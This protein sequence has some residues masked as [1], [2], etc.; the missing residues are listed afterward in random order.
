MKILALGDLHLGAGADLGAPGERLAEQEQV[1]AWSLQQARERDVDVVLFAGDA[2]Q[3]RKPSVDALLAFERPLVE[4]KNAGGPQVLAIPGNH[5]LSSLDAGCAL[6][7]FHQDGLIRLEREPRVVLVD[8]GALVACLP[9]A[10]TSRLAARLDVAAEDVNSAAAHLL[11]EVARTL[12]EDAG[13]GAKPVILLTHFSI[14]GTS[15]PS[16]LPVDQLREPVLDQDDLLAIGYDAVIAGHIHRAGAFGP[17][18]DR[19]I[20]FGH[21]HQATYGNGLHFYTG[22]PLALNF[23]E[24]SVAHGVWIIDMD[25]APYST[26]LPSPS[27]RFVNL[28]YGIGDHDDLYVDR[29]MSEHDVEGAYVKLR[30]AGT[31]EQM[32]RV[33]VQTYKACLEEDGAHRVFVDT[34]V[35]REARARDRTVDDSLSEREALERWMAAQNGTVDHDVAARALE[36][37]QGY[38]ERVIS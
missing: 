33:E 7:I 38:L 36:R 13:Y 3:H 20:L 4:H 26:F 15:L 22:S 24:A 30:I 8:G 9:W 19:H 10:P 6:D 28:A 27:R 17:S 34:V 25:G 23:G 14:S 32:K 29:A 31:D 37:A 2:F 5:D 21:E 16:G 1:W 11:V 12:R 18:L 35:E